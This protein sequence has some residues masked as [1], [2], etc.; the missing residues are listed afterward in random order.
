MGDV[1]ID[2]DAGSSLP[3]PPIDRLGDAPAPPS[4]WP[5]LVATLA[6]LFFNLNNLC[7]RFYFHTFF[8]FLLAKK[9]LLIFVNR[10]FTNF[11][12]YFI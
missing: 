5:L 1:S 8:D 12:S 6:F 10:R 4:R 7:M 2:E 9:S 3:T 11:T